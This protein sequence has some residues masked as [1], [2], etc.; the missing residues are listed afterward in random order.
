MD[1]ATTTSTATRTVVRAFGLIVALAG[2]EHGVGEILQGAVRPSG[3]VVAAWPDARFFRV[4]GGEPALVLIPDLRLAGVLTLVVCVAFALRAWYADR[5]PH[6]RVHLIALA[7]ILL[8]AG[9]GFGP[10]LLGCA[11]SLLAG[12]LVS[13]EPTSQDRLD[14]RRWMAHSFPGSLYA[15]IGAW[16]LVLPGLPLL[17][18]LVGVSDILVGPAVAVAAL[19][20]WF[21]AMSAIGA[22]AMA[23]QRGSSTGPP[24]GTRPSTRIALPTSNDTWPGTPPD[25][26]D[27]P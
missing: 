2:A 25:E 20:L 26:R 7:I 12:R 19:A 13:S 14:S 6:A 1:T 10:P 22:D 4:E 18:V 11:V 15:A 23:A 16:L 27:R 3:A 21:A 9:G 8:L 17:D 5:G 24:S